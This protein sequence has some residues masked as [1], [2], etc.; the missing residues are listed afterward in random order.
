MDHED[1]LGQ[2]V[3]ALKTSAVMEVTLSYSLDKYGEVDLRGARTGQRQTHRGAA[4]F[5]KV[6]AA[7][8]QRSGRWTASSVSAPAFKQSQPVTE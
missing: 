7:Q 2:L 3:Q 8:V 6:L 4:P 5:E 1:R